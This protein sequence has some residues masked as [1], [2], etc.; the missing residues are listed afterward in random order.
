MKTGAWIL[1]L[2]IAL[3]LLSPSFS[4]ADSDLSELE[5]IIKDINAKQTSPEKV[6]KIED[7]L[8]E[9]YGH[10]VDPSEISGLIQKH[11]PGE[12]ITF[13]V[14]MKLL[15]KTDTK[16]VEMKKK[17]LSPEHKAKLKAG[18]LAALEKRKAA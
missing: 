12:A 1:A 13:V 8:I 5:G 9:V 11:T 7:K 16:V 2:F 18:R 4:S 6:S 3:V 15:E 14:F 17:T 10:V